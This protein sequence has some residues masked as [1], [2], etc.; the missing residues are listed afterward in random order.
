MP[1]SFSPPESAG[2]RVIPWV[3]EI[4]RDPR[5][6]LERDLAHPLLKRMC[7]KFLGRVEAA[8]HGYPTKKYLRQLWK[9]AAEK[10]GAEEEYLRADE[11]HTRMRGTPVEHLVASAYAFEESQ[12]P[13]PVDPLERYSAFLTHDL[14]RLTRASG[15]AGDVARARLERRSIEE[16][17]GFLKL[18]DR[19]AEWIDGWRPLYMSYGNLTNLALQRKD[20]PPALLEKL[21]GLM[22]EKFESVHNVEGYEVGMIFG[23]SSLM[24]GLAAAEMFVKWNE[25]QP[26]L[27][28]GV[29]QEIANDVLESMH[30]PADR[31]HLEEFLETLE[32]DDIEQEESAWRRKVFARACC[33]HPVIKKAVAGCLRSKMGIGDPRPMIEIVTQKPPRLQDGMMAVMEQHL[34]TRAAAADCLRHLSFTAAQHWAPPAGLSVLGD[35]PPHVTHPLSVS[36]NAL[37]CEIATFASL[38]RRIGGKEWKATATKLKTQAADAKPESGPLSLNNLRSVFGNRLLSA[39][40]LEENRGEEDDAATVW[41]RLVEKAK[42]DD[43]FGLLLMGQ[44]A[45]WLRS[46]DRNAASA[47]VLKG[48]DHLAGIEAPGHVESLQETIGCDRYREK[49]TYYRDR[50]EWKVVEALE[51]EIIGRVMRE[52]VQY[53]YHKNADDESGSFR[54]GFPR[55]IVESKSITCFSGPWLLSTMLLRCGFTYDQLLYCNVFRQAKQSCFG[56]HGGL[57]ISTTEKELVMADPIHGKLAR[58]LRL[59]FCADPGEQTEMRSLLSGGSNAPVNL[60]IDPAMARAIELPDRMQVMQLATGFISSHLLHI[61]IMLKKKEEFDQAA[62][63]FEMGLDVHP[64]DPDLLYERGLIEFTQGRLTTARPFLNLAIAVEPEHLLARFALGELESREGNEAGAAAHFQA[65]VDDGRTIW[66]DTGGEILKEAG[67]YL[68]L[69]KEKKLV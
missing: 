25:D 54:G 2:E 62:Y 60:R 28:N 6:A 4:V 43:T 61:G 30:L 48:W 33:N 34:R 8:V 58:P 17:L 46:G 57:L 64:R 14:L 52:I 16:L 40:Q 65:V 5:A 45:S 47:I 44:F 39:V 12:M 9:I 41:G 59:S 19:D 69:L 31:T 49:L 3:E 38:L 26:H 21:I 63:A 42:T 35:L 37:N 56:T 68:F 10:L 24:P 11:R 32:D 7:P 29:I 36:P 27:F 13:R 67:R 66:G 50:K 23:E 20:V 55:S 22:T 15:T 18:E 53:P 51:N 1:E